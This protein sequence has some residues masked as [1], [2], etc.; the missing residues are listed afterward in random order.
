MFIDDYIESE[1]K[2]HANSDPE[3]ECCG[4]VVFSSRDKVN[5]VF[6]CENRSGHKDRHFSISPR[7]YLKASNLGSIIA[8]Y[9]SHTSK[10]IDGFSE[11]D[12]IQ[13]EAHELPCILYNTA[14][15]KFLTYEPNDY[16]FPYIGRAFQIGN[17]DCF[18]LLTDYYNNELSINF[19]SFKRGEL[20]SN[21]LTNFSK[22][23]MKEVGLSPRST[24][25][26]NLNVLV[27]KESLIEIKR[28]RPDMKKIINHDIILFKYYDLDK[29]S[30]CGIYIGGNKVL[31]QPARA[32][33]RVQ[34]Y[35]DSL[36][37]KTYCVLRHESL[38]N[39]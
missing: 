2:K 29:P 35:S 13:S 6:P 5:V 8:V 1:I 10:N 32:Y 25:L 33:S 4:F 38:A 3:N 15:D 26:E 39:G 20:W 19:D 31:H 23:K 14:G 37:R 9:H 27:E 12:K 11:F 28:G 7:D 30:H 16:K 24:F 17:Q 22:Q 21:D 36:Q 34:D 18:T